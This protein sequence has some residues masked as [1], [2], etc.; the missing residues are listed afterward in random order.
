MQPQHAS[1]VAGRKMDMAWAE[2][3]ALLSLFRG[4]LTVQSI[5]VD[6][7]ETGLVVAERY[8]LSTYDVMFAASA[9]HAGCDTLWYEDMQDG[10]LIEG[11]LRIVSLF[12]AKGR[13]RTRG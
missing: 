13:P 11:R 2:T 9:L 12:G 10:L 7:H 3:H 5:T 6:I 8:G 4:P 1:N